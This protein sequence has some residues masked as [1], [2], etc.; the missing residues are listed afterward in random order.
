MVPPLISVIMP[1]HNAVAYVG[2]AVESVLTQTFGDF[3]L[4][5]VDDASSDGSG[6]VVRGIEDAR[7]R[8]IRSE[9]QLN[10]AGARNLGMAEAKGEFVAFLDA[11]DVALPRRLAVQVEFFREHP[12]VG[13]LGTQV[14][15]ID[16]NG[17]FVSHGL[18]TR[19]SP[20]IPGLLLFENCIA[21]SS[22]MVRR[23]LLKPF[24]PEFAPAEDYDLWAR[25]AAKIAFYILP[26]A[27]TQYRVNPEGVSAREP[28]RMQ[29]AVEAIH[30]WQLAA[31]GVHEVPSVHA[32][33]AGWPISADRE[34]VCR[35]EQW[36]LA[37]KKINDQAGG[38]DRQAFDQILAERWF[39]VCNDSWQLG[40]WVLK[41]YWK[42]PLRR[43]GHI[44]LGQKCQILR[45]VLS[46][47]IRKLGRD[48]H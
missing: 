38:Y 25:L 37:L 12:E 7:V 39:M 34:T 15:M 44:T 22:V 30:S 36:L 42:S 26:Q 14:D 43:L 18:G 41:I 40:G 35:A 8:L 29:K 6:E 46:Q 13:L 48:S 16:Q 5:V 17:S 23:E 19:P 21:L 28:E 47:V 20:Q 9:V 2:E 3:E 10:A 27:L 31:L 33:L 24:R 45:R 4:I 32:L 11:D 1:L